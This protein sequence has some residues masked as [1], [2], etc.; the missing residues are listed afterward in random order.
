VDGQHALLQDIQLFGSTST[1]AGP[2]EF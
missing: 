2:S 1:A